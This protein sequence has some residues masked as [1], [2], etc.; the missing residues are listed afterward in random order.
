[1]SERVSRRD[2]LKKVSLTVLAGGL[3]G[4]G[5]LGCGKKDLTCTDVAGL[6]ADEASA[7]T[8]LGYGDKS[9]DAAK[10]CAN[11]LQ[12]TAGQPNAC[13]ACKVM[14]GPIHPAGYCKVWAQKPA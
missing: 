8:T 14:K 6:S 1:M 7:R 3:G 4:F 13:G 2:A 10:N 9:P 11:C 12:Y 5:A